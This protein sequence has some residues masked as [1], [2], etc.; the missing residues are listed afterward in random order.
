MKILAL[1]LSTAR[2]SLA[3][4]NDGSTHNSINQI[5]FNDG[6][7]STWPNDRKDS[8]PFFDNLQRV[9]RGFGLPDK[10][11]VGLGPGSYAGVR[12]AISAAVGLGA[13]GGGELVGCPSVCAMDAATASYVVIGDA[14]RRSF[15]LARI[16]NRNVVGEYA[17]LDESALRDRLNELDPAIAVLSADRLP[18]FQPRVEQRFPS[19]EVLARLAADAERQFSMPP[20]EPIYLR[21]PNVTIPKPV[22]GRANQ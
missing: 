15:F 12:I 7:T 4:L 11:V 22:F 13:A 6:Q 19:A 10:I 16:S 2:G 18:Q 21:E 14:R 3:L 1:E 8:G 5:T 9:I 17:L 20:L